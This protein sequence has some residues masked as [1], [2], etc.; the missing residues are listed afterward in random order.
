[1]H[2]NEI[3]TKML[4]GE[5][6]SL[7]K[8]ISIVESSSPDTGKIMQGIF[9]HCNGANVIG[10]TGPPGAGK[11]SVIYHLAKTISDQS[12]KV[13]VLA[14]DPNSH[15]TGGALL[16][17]RIRM[18]DL[19]DVYI[20]SIGNRCS[21]GG[22]SSS[23][24]FII[25]ILEA[26]KYEYIFIETVG[27]GQSE[28]KIKD[29]ADITMLILAPGL[30]DDI[31]AN[32]A[33]IMEIGDIIV[34]NKADKPDALRLEMELKD[35][36]KTSQHQ[37]ANTQVFQTDSINGL[38]FNKLVECFPSIISKDNKTKEIE[39]LKTQYLELMEN[40]I[41]TLVH[42]KF[43]STEDI[44]ETMEDVLNGEQNVIDLINKDIKDIIST[45][46]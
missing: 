26:C 1:M 46:I 16:G 38:G 20:R 11:S 5:V 35:M 15:V 37:N 17:D 43:N 32:K 30:G 40:K 33:G 39:K 21:M 12:K 24:Y 9:P 10:I 3:I 36:L 34:V 7:A 14:I 29:L 22:V 31:Q 19:K 23:T 27:V 13:A 6:Y 45:N 25:K 8:V 2:N 42:N 41:I 44:D 28:V 18:D 4:D